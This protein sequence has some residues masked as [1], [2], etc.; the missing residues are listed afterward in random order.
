M[1]YL[2][3]PHVPATTYLVT[4]VLLSHVFIMSILNY[5][6]IKTKRNP[7]DP[8]GPLSAEIPSSTIVTVNKKARLAIVRSVSK[9]GNQG[10]YVHLTP[11]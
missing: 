4:S 9:D 3:V 2:S 6:K 8:N 11:E 5:F 7:P 1:I 10:P